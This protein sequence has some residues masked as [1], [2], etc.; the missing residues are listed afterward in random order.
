MTN[1][2]RPQANGYTR[3]QEFLDAING[4]P[5]NYGTFEADIAGKR[6][7]R[8]LHVTHGQ[9]SA[10]AFIELETGDILKPAGYKGPAKHAR[11]NIFADDHGLSCCGR[12]SVAYLR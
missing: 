11:G 9:R 8:I 2:L 10:Y 12:Y 1:I 4:R 7:V 6:Y 5:D 3:L